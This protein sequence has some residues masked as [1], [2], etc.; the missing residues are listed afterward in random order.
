MEKYKIVIKSDYFASEATLLWNSARQTFICIAAKPNINF[1]ISWTAA[2]IKG[3]CTDRK[4]TLEIVKEEEL[5][6]KE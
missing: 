2:K 1:M 5:V 3:Y 4:W 6:E